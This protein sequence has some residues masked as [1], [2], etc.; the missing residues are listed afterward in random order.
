MPCIH[1]KIEPIGPI[2]EFGIST[3]SV[4][5][6]PGIPGPPIQWMRALIDTGCSHTSIHSSSAGK[7]GLNVISKGN[8][9]TPTAITPVD[10]YLGDAILRPIVG[11]RPFEWRFISHRFNELLHPNPNFE[12]L[13]GMDIIGQGTLVV[14]GGMQVAT[15]CW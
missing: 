5:I 4:V 3:P 15:F 6:T 9:I 13:M 12:V 1:A 2:V 8:V 10:I 7:C 14:N 11:G